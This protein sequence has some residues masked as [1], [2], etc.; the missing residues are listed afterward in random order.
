MSIEERFYQFHD[1]LLLSCAPSWTLPSDKSYNI[2]LFTLGFFLPLFV[3]CATSLSVIKNV[4]HVNILI[5][6]HIESIEMI[7][8][9]RPSVLFRHQIWYFLSDLQLIFLIPCCLLKVLILASIFLF[10]WGP[11]AALSLPC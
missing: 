1:S 8:S 5:Y 2:F 3:I 11:Y 9:F 4:K 6:F 7:L 10:C